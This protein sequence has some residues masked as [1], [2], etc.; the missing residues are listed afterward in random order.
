MRTYQ[1]LEKVSSMRLTFDPSWVDGCPGCPGPVIN[2]AIGDYM[3]AIAVKNIAVKLRNQSIQKEMLSLSREMAEHASRGL[4]AGYEDGDDIC[5]PWWPHPHFHG[6][7]PPPPPPI[8]RDL[9]V[10]VVDIAGFSDSMNELMLAGALKQLASLTTNR[11]FS[12]RIFWM[13]QSIV[14]NALS[15]VFDDYCGT[16]PPPRPKPKYEELNIRIVEMQNERVEV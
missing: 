4:L 16:V 13:G 11:N 5:P 3:V 15:E 6:P 7:Y 8:D 9:E 10:S 1:L 12:E 2:E 14:K